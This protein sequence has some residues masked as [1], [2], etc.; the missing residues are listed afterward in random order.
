MSSQNQRKRRRTRPAT[1]SESCYYC[2]Q[3]GKKCNRGRKSA[4]CAN[5]LPKSTSPIL[6]ADS[7]VNSDVRQHL[8]NLVENSRPFS[9]QGNE[10]IACTLAFEIETEHKKK[11]K[12]KE[13][14][15]TNHSLLIM[16]P[17]YPSSQALRADMDSFV[18]KHLSL[19]MRCSDDESHSTEDHAEKHI[20]KFCLLRFDALVEEV[21]VPLRALGAHSGRDYALNTIA[22][23]G[24]LY[25]EVEHVNQGFQSGKLRLL[26]TNPDM[27]KSLRIWL[28]GIAQELLARL[29]TTCGSFPVWAEHL[30]P[31]RRGAKRNF[32]IRNISIAIEPSSIVSSNT[33][34]GQE[35]C[36]PPDFGWSIA[37]SAAAVSPASTTAE[38]EPND[39]VPGSEGQ[40]EQEQTSGYETTTSNAAVTH[41]SNPNRPSGATSYDA[42]DLTLYQNN[43]LRGIEKLHPENSTSVIVD[44]TWTQPFPNDDRAL[45]Q[46]YLSVDDY[47]FTPPNEKFATM[48]SY[49]LPIS[50]TAEMPSSSHQPFYVTGHSPSEK[51]SDTSGIMALDYDWTQNLFG[52]VTNQHVTWPQS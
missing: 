33:G 31:P 16:E 4:C 25:C 32:D 11:D 50:S 27:E 45:P 42:V 40:I 9:S 28:K 17:F 18:W 23:A 12:S 48:S 10:V 14:R 49:D 37:P 19:Q 46:N 8:D 34:M 6:N 38:S 26:C 41:A 20:I 7:L 29:Q 43:F 21:I 24:V 35:I 52:S 13:T 51:T 15:Q 44:R 2:F 3:R 1:S 39:M 22:A 5:C 36:D 30:V 47:H